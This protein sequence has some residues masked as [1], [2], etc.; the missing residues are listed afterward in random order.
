M[1]KIV[2]FILLVIGF[3][4]ILSNVQ[5]QTNT[6]PLVLNSFYNVVKGTNQDTVGA[7]QT[8][9]TKRYF[10]NQPE[11]L[12]YNITVKISDYASGFKGTL[13]LKKRANAYSPLSTV[14]TVTYAGTGTDTTITFSQD[15]LK[16]TAYIYELVL[17]RTAS[18]GKID[19]TFFSIKK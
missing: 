11:A 9:I 19:T 5:A 10:V 18:K 16:S 17:N 2:S 7:T 15:T 14:A 12:L 3:V 4:S 6:T 1:R 13:A 8:V